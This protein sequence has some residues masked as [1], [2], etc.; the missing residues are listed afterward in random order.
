MYV[1]FCSVALLAN[2]SDVSFA[3]RKEV[4]FFDK[5][6]PQLIRRTRDL[7]WE[8]TVTAYLAT[9]RAVSVGW[10]D[11]YKVPEGGRF[12]DVSFAGD[13]ED[14]L[15]PTRWIRN[16]KDGSMKP[17]EGMWPGRAV[18]EATPFYIAHMSACQMMASLLPGVRLIVLVR[19]P[20]DRVFSE[21][22]MKQRRIEAQEEFV[23]L[24]LGLAKP[25]HRCL[26]K[27]VGDTK[28]LESCVLGQAEQ[29][30]AEGSINTARDIRAMVRHSHWKKWMA[31]VKAEVSRAFQGLTK[32]SSSSSAAKSA[33]SRARWMSVVAK[34]FATHP[35]EA[36][37][38]RSPRA[39]VKTRSALSNIMASVAGSDVRVPTKKA[40]G[41]RGRPPTRL[42]LSDEL[43]HNSSSLASSPQLATPLVTH[44]PLP[45]RRSLPGSLDALLR[46]G[47]GD[48]RTHD[49]E[50][51][52][53]DPSERGA[54]QNSDMRG[55][56]HTGFTHLSVPGAFNSSS[57]SARRLL[58]SSF[59][60]S[61]ASGGVEGNV[62]N[63]RTWGPEQLHFQPRA[64]LGTLAAEAV[65]PVQEAL[66]GEASI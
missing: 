15:A 56:V 20:V 29:L 65:E 55:D 28:K 6:L 3:T 30:E 36:P 48:S 42:L 16:S 26:T 43:H 31:A 8:D 54:R 22:S 17:I 34:C 32:P 61:L 41:L 63:L 27:C 33:G 37:K 50:N 21:Y 60:S 44:F 23:A 14:K 10:C 11:G 4:H 12:A 45:R 1:C 5:K 7:S 57:S 25:L 39:H 2:H 49:D 64:C 59:S 62:E 58:S 46:G 51:G 38:K 9:F 40:A 52:L 13:G 35:E 47:D 53:A 66:L 19:D 18:M 24:T